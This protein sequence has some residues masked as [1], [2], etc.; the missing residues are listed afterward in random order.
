MT[1]FSAAHSLEELTA[2]AWALEDGMERFYQKLAE[3]ASDA[4]AASLFRDLVAAEE[5]HKEMLVGLLPAISGTSPRSG[6]PSLLEVA[7]KGVMEG[8]MRV[9]EALAWASGKGVKQILELALS[10]E[11]GSYDRY[12]ALARKADQEKWAEVFARL[13]AEEKRHLQ[14]LMELFEKRL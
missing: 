12:R 4:E 10:L 14:L 11:T 7:E 2:M 3:T 13:A 6:F 8:G 5:G 9:D 1:W